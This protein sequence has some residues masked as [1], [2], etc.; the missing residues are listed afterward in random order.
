[1]E[2]KLTENQNPDEVTDDVVVSLDYTLTV[3]GE[4]IDSSDDTGPIEF[5]QG[6]GEIIP[7]L[8]RE[9]QGMKLA[10]VRDVKVAPGEAYGEIDPEAVIDVPRSDFP[11]DLPV[12]PGTEI[13]VRDNEGN[14]MDARIIEVKPDAITLDFNHPLAGKSLEF[15]VKVVGLRSPTEEELAHGH[16]HSDDNYHSHEE[17]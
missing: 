12:E 5:I 9:I 6:N 7:G 14:A 15:H 4:L 13:E 17:D 1:V 10:E 3:E 11:D 16:V 8:E 2:E